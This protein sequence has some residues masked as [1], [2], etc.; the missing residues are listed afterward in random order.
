MF[1]ISKQLFMIQKQMFTNSKQIFTIAEQIIIKKKPIFTNKK[2]ITMINNCHDKKR[3]TII[4][5]DLELCE[6]ILFK[7]CMNGMLNI[8]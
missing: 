8:I 1:I 3:R 6:K 7:L 5:F 4:V 2:T